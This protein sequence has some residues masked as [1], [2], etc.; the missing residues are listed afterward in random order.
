MGIDADSEPAARAALATAQ[1]SPWRETVPPSLVVR[2][3]TGE[4]PV[5]AAEDM[6][7]QLT[8]VLEDGTRRDL[9][10]LDE[11]VETQVIGANCPS[12]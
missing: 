7:P 5:F 4:M 2:R 3:G 12:K 8:I 9:R 6:D 11:V 1:Q 10:V